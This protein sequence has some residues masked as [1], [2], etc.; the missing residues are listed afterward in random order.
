MLLHLT[1]VQSEPVAHPT[2][3]RPRFG[4]H[5]ADQLRG[6]PGGSAGAGEDR[7]RGVALAHRLDQAAAVCLDRLGNDRIVADEDG[8]HLPR[9]PLPQIRRAFDVGHADGHDPGGD[10]GLPTGAEALDELPGR[11]GTSGGI[12]RSAEPDRLLEHAPPLGFEVGWPL[13]LSS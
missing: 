12:G 4:L 13:G 2:V 11:R 7:D 1:G 6:R 10:I 9:V 3:D 5:P 8:T